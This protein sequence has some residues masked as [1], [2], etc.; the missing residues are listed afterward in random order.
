MT[1]YAVPSLFA[2]AIKLVL[3]AYA[4]KSATKNAITKVFLAFLIVLSLF[5][6]VECFGFVYYYRHGLAPGVQIIGFAYI[7]LL[8]P[9]IALLLHVSLAL[10]FDSPLFGSKKRYLTML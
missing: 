1:F 10:S 7:A 9:A 8:I 2:L 5:N 4:A 3:L 6:A